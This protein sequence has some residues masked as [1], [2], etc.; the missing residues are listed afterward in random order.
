MTVR[1]QVPECT[2]LPVCQL[3]V[4]H[5]PASLLSCRRQPRMQALRLSHP[6]LLSQLIMKTSH[7]WLLM[8]SRELG[9]TWYDDSR[10]LITSIPL[11]HLMIHETELCELY[12]RRVRLRSK[13]LQGDAYSILRRIQLAST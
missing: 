2:A 13:A 1:C 12:C 9:N 6:W 7:C 10:A 3:T 4:M 11:K 8:H 5:L